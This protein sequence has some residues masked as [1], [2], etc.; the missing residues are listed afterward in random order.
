M[1][2]ISVTWKHGHSD[3]PVRMASESD[4]ERFERRKLEFFI[5]GI[6]HCAGPQFEGPRTQLGTAAVPSLAAIN[7]DPQFDGIE[8]PEAEFGRSWKAHARPIAA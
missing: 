4:D 8:I 5:D 1:K 6:V 2:Y 3:Y 7:E